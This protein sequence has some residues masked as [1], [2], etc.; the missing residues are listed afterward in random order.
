M[1][2]GA[3]VVLNKKMNRFELHDDYVVHWISNERQC[4]EHTHS[5]IEFVYHSSGSALHY[6]NRIA[7][8]MKKGDL[9][10]IDQGGVHSFESKSTIKYCDIMLKPSFFDK[11]LGKGGDLD[12]VL[13]LEEFRTFRSEIRKGQRLIHFSSEEQ[14]KVELLLQVTIE[15]QRNGQNA[16]EQMKRSALYMLLTMIFRKMSEPERLSVNHELTEYIAAHF[17]EGLTAGLLAERCGYTKEHF[18]RKFKQYT[19]KNFC[20]Y[21]NTLRLSRA[22]EL[23]LTTEK[24]VDEIIDSSGFSSRGEFFQKF[25]QKFGKTP[26]QFRKSKRSQKS[27]Q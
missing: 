22:E 13:S 18:S 27:V 19:G 6:V 25:Q 23:L 10:L 7:Y 12:A 14:K 1:K 24:S 5:Y 17:H 9:L 21:L 26:L 4:S 16:T 3:N 15:E 8:P 2:K 11:N 20:A